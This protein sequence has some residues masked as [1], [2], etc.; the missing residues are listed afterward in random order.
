[1]TSDFSAKL[2]VIHSARTVQSVFLD[3]NI[4]APR[5]TRI[6]DEI[7][8]VVVEPAIY[9]R[10]WQRCHVD[11]KIRQIGE[12]RLMGRIPDRLV[13][14]CGPRHSHAMDRTGAAAN[15]VTRPPAATA[16]KLPTGLSSSRRSRSHASNTALSISTPYS[17]KLDAC[18]ALPFRVGISII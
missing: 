6:G 18:G 14:R 7:M 8:I 15:R 5:L 9:L 3:R 12:L 2:P 1:M 10:H 17:L 4:D 16:P 11:R 13:E